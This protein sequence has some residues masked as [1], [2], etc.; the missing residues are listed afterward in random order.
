MVHM[1][2]EQN[3]NI[4][5]YSYCEADLIHS[6]KANVRA[7]IYVVVG[8]L[9]TILLIWAIV[10]TVSCIGG[11]LG[12]EACIETAACVDS[13]TMKKGCDDCRTSIEEGWKSC[14]EYYY[15]DVG[16]WEKMTT[17]NVENAKGCGTCAG[18]DG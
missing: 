2:Y 6:A 16:C 13:C 8:A 12:C 14:E 10:G 18:D 9:L 15:G 5:D 3:E 7:F 4:I 11:C 1:D 17:E